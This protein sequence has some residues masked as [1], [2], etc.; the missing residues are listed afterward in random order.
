[1]GAIISYGLHDCTHLNIVP[2]ISSFDREGN[3]SPLYVRINGEAFKIYN[4]HQTNSTLQ[5]L[6]FK[7]EV[8]VDDC[9]RPLNLIYHVREHKWSTPIVFHRRS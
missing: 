5:L 6:N 2:V 3:I 4:A 9:I 1:M 8:I 7:C